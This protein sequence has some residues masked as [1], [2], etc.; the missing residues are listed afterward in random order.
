MQDNFKF[1]D[2][3]EIVRVSCPSPDLVADYP[4]RRSS[5]WRTMSSR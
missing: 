1:G 4:V 5:R 3:K 2:D